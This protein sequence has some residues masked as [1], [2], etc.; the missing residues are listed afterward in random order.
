[1]ID[2]EEFQTPKRGALHLKNH[3]CSVSGLS[4]PRSS[5]GSQ[6]SSIFSP[7]ES[8]SSDNT[9]YDWSPT[10]GN[11]GDGLKEL[12]TLSIP[13]IK[14]EDTDT[15][16]RSLKEALDAPTHPSSTG[17]A[18]ST[19]YLQFDSNPF[20]R[21]AITVVKGEAGSIPKL[22]LLE[23]YNQTIGGLPHKPH[24]SSNLQTAQRPSFSLTVNF[25]FTDDQRHG[26][27]GTEYRSRSDV[28]VR[29]NPTEVAMSQPGLRDEH[30]PAQA[31]YPSS[32]T[33]LQESIDNVCFNDS[34]AKLLPVLSC[35]LLIPDGSSCIATTKS[36]NM[37]C[38]IKIRK[39]DISV[40]RNCLAKIRADG[41]DAAEERIKEFLGL[42]L[43][44]V[45]QGIA[46]RLFTKLFGKEAWQS[47]PR[48]LLV[49]TEWLGKLAST[50]EPISNLVDSKYTKADRT[51]VNNLSPSRGPL[52]PQVFQ[53]HP[54]ARSGKP[55]HME[56]REY[57]TRPLTSDDS[58]QRGFIYVFWYPGGFGHV[59]I[60]FAADL[61]KRMNDWSKQ[62]GRKPEKYFPSEQADLE[63]VPH[64]RRVEK[65]VH[66]ELARYRKEELECG[67]CGKRHV[68]WFEVDVWFA[69]SVVRKWVNWMQER[70]YAPVEQN[71]GE[72]R[73]MLSKKHMDNIAM[74][75]T[76]TPIPTRESKPT[77][78]STPRKSV[79]S[80][81][82]LL[83]APKRNSHR[84]SKR[85]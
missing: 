10:R 53:P 84:R 66:A 29:S 43:C 30:E 82:A 24:N 54:A 41:V 13:S 27:E 35:D 45:H 14:A 39:T 58:T 55:I 19:T 32:S 72:I 31:D 26:K 6:A 64:R 37:R 57:L 71:N 23:T 4:T 76:P 63:P 7:N 80:N 68:E 51:A 15:V 40:I 52:P 3:G 60:G 18:K 22:G 25:R 21:S 79:S 9:E 5:L 65:L 78:S 50:G 17:K 38:K 48:S 67:K 49:L 83:S 74:L 11:E 28:G 81:T 44:H 42:V 1:M 85:L 12:S 46:R 75:S 77:R 59:K 56:I 16:D 34:L 61:K 69:I 62:C 2:T 33:L 73:W 20:S 47:Q 36:R 8:V 70:P